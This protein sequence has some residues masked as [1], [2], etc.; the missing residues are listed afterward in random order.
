MPEGQKRLSIGRGLVGLA[1]AAIL[2]LGALYVLNP[3]PG[4]VT[5]GAVLEGIYALNVGYRPFGLLGN[6]TTILALRFWDGTQVSFEDTHDAYRPGMP[7]SQARA[8]YLILKATDGTNDERKA[9]PT[10]NDAYRYL[11][12]EI[13]RAPLSPVPPGTAS[14]RP[15]A[16]EAS[17]TLD[18]SL[19]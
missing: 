19:L 17:R 7:I 15:P 1:T 9:T 3:R 4:T 10:D 6:D 5:R 18:A 13:E 12:E 2:G 14:S 16:S 8:E 11:L